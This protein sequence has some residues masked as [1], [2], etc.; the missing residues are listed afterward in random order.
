MQTGQGGVYVLI[1]EMRCLL[2]LI[3][4]LASAQEAQ[5]V[6]GTTVVIP[7]GLRG[8]VYHLPAGTDSLGILKTLNPG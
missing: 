3:P 7:S 4:L 5:P 1:C 6:F 8:E 2:L